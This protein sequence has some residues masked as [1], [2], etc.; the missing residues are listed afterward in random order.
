MNDAVGEPGFHNR[1]SYTG[2]N[3]VNRVDRNG[4]CWMNASASPDQ[5]NQCFD[6]WSGYADVVTDTYTQNW[7][8]D[9]QI[10][11]TQEAQYWTGLSYTEF[12]SQWNSSRSPSQMGPGTSLQATGGAMVLQ[13]VAA[14]QIEPVVPG[15]GDAVGIPWALIGVC[16]AGIGA[17]A[18]A[19]GTITLPMRQPYYFT[20]S[21]DDTESQDREIPKISCPPCPRPNPKCHVDRVP[22]ARSHPPCSGDHYHEIIVN[23][24]PLTCQC[25]ETRQ[26]YLTPANCISPQGAAPPNPPCDTWV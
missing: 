16:V 8:R 20:Q 11:M 17:I 6:A 23:Q 24:D 3:P 10:L 26:S 25:F 15:P 5:Q 7:P 12:V 9:V 4:M 1:Y 22:P 19:T 14:S 2:G 18:N 13:G 21:N